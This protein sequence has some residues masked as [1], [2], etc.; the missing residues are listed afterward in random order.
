[1]DV[2]EKKSYKKFQFTKKNQ[3]LK[4]F[5]FQFDLPVSLWSNLALRFSYP[6]DHVSFIIDL[7]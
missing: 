5:F 7:T 1:M 4:K 3:W 2:K 6:N